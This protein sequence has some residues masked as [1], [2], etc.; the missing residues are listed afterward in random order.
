MRLSEVNK[1]LMNSNGKLFGK[2]SIIDLLVILLVIIAIVG[3]YFR[4]TQTAKPNDSSEAN[5]QVVLKTTDFYYTINIKEIREVNKNKLVESVNSEFCLNG[6]VTFTMGTLVGV[7]VSDSVAT[8]TLTDGSIVQAEIPEKYD[9]ALTFKISG[10]EKDDGYFT[11]QMY[12][13][14]VGRSYSISSLYST[15]YGTIEKIWK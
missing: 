7:D 14:C 3:A 4:L 13:L 8:I 12:E 11:P 5:K 9:V 6:D 1:M 15:V 2:V 10:Y